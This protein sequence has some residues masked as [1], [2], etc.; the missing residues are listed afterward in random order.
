MNDVSPATTAPPKHGLLNFALDFGPLLLFFVAYR[1][2]GPT[3]NPVTAAITGTV[4]FMVAIII[5]LVVSKWKLGR[6]SPMMGFSALLILGFGALTI[7]F[8]DLRFI[9]HKP[10]FIYLMFAAILFIGLMRGKAAL[11]YLLE[12]A[13]AGLSD[14]G[15]IKLSRNWALF[16][17]FLAGLNEAMVAILTQEQWVTAKVWGVT[18]LTMIFAIANIPMLMRHGLAVEG[19]TKADAIEVPPQ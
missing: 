6:I 8:R 1:L 4:V 11:K 9:Q 15:W 16:F 13:Y 10:T 3:E 17:L 7:Y 2:S 19:T 14:A 18:A 12:Y 5:A